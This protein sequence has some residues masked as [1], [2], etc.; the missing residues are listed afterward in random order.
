LTIHPFNHRRA[1]QQNSQITRALGRRRSRALARRFSRLRSWRLRISCMASPGRPYSS[2]SASHETPCARR[3]QIARSSSRRIASRSGS[4]GKIMRNAL[5][6]Y[7]DHP[8]FLIPSNWSSIRYGQSAQEP[9]PQHVDVWIPRTLLTSRQRCDAIFG[10]DIS[11]GECPLVARTARDRPYA[12]PRSPP[13][14][15][16]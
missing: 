11:L 16:V 10:A 13:R 1:Q 14:E 8:K 2:P 6:R 5:R 3:A 15:N 4:Y 12:P 7:P 9:R